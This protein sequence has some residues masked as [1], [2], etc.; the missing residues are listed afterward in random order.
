MKSQ[1]EKWRKRLK[2]SK[3]KNE[4]NVIY[5]EKIHFW[6]N[7][8]FFFERENKWKS[9]FR[10]GIFLWYIHFFF[11][12]SFIFFHKVCNFF[13]FLP[14]WIDI[15]FP[16]KQMFMERKIINQEEKIRKFFLV[17]AFLLSSVIFILFS[18]KNAIYLILFLFI[19]ISLLIVSIPFKLQN[20]I[21]LFFSSWIFE[22]FLEN[23]SRK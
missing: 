16:K 17:K 15:F 7:L 3:R 6:E 4:N 18:S 14:P 8:C 23:F 21:L 5:L 9:E 10:K 11:S 20:V 19:F 2:F 22:F 13:L 12:R 1:E